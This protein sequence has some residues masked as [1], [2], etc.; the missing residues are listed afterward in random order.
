MS[1][2]QCDSRKTNRRAVLRAGAGVLATAGF[3]GCLGGGG[4]SNDSNS[5]SGN[6]SGGD[7]SP[8]TAASSDSTTS[9]GSGEK[10]TTNGTTTAMVADVFDSGIE[11]SDR[12]MHIPLNTDVGLN[13][14]QLNGPNGGVFATY[15]PHQYEGEATFTLIK[16]TSERLGYEPYPFGTYTA[17]AVRGKSTVD[18]HS[19]D[20]RPE[21]SVTGIE[22]QQGFVAITIENIGT[23]PAPITA[24]RVYRSSMNPGRQEFGG[25]FIDQNAIVAPEESIT[26]ETRLMGFN[27]VYSVTN[28]SIE[29]ANFCCVHASIACSTL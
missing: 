11:F 12:E 17:K 25:G 16:Q 18:S 7:S 4:S 13:A 8:T 2:D 3:A 26:I 14:V 24:A 21:F 9:G 5:G 1:S 29:S 22:S 28:G 23:A 6:D 20:L 19:Y 15:E 10:G 27:D